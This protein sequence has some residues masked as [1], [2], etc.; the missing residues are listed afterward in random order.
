MY[1]PKHHFVYK[2]LL[3]VPHFP[4]CLARQTPLINIQTSAMLS[5][6][7]T[8]KN[9][10]YK[11]PNN[12]PPTPHAPYITVNTPVNVFFVYIFQRRYRV[13]STNISNYITS[14]ALHYIPVIQRNNAF[15]AYQAFGILATFSFSFSYHSGC[16]SFVCCADF[17]FYSDAV[18]LKFVKALK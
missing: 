8:G 12:Q 9:F 16:Y 10:P 14:L 6:R 3:L 1:P 4:R 15:E 11:H 18:S 17:S 5:T 7:H 2:N 13:S